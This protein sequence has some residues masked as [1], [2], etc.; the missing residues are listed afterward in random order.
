[1]S[2]NIDWACLDR[3]VPVC[4]DIDCISTRMH[5]TKAKLK[6]LGVL[7]YTCPVCKGEWLWSVLPTMRDYGWLQ[8]R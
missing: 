4:P 1:M 8:T 3:D 6:E 7:H 5:G 2:K